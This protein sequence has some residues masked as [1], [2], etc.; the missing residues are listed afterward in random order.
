MIAERYRVGRL[1]GRG[2]M[3]MV[4]VGEHV[5]VG[6]RVA[7]KVMTDNWSRNESI[8]RRFEAEARAASAAGHPNV[9]QVLDV[10]ELDDGRLYSVMEFIEGRDLYTLLWAEHPLSLIRACRLVRDAAFGVRAAHAQG[11]IHR[12]L[13]LE[14]V[15]VQDLREGELVKVLDFGIA[16]GVI[17]GK[18]ATMAGMTMGTPE[19]M[20]PEQV[21]GVDPTVRFDI[22]ALGVMLFE[23]LAKRLPLEDDNPLRLLA[24]KG[25]EPA[26][27]VQTLRQDVPD[28]LDQ[29]V[30]DCL[31]IDP[32]R[33]PQSCEVFIERLSAIVEYL[34]AMVVTPTDPIAPSLPPPRA[35][36]MTRSY[37]D[38]GGAGPSA[39][40]VRVAGQVHSTVVD[41]EQTNPAATVPAVLVGSQPARGAGPL[42]WVLVG[43]FGFAAIA[44]GGAL[45]W[46]ESTA[47]PGPVASAEPDVRVVSSDSLGD[48]GEPELLAQPDPD[49]LDKLDEL[50]EL[51]DSEDLER[52]GASADAR[53]NIGAD[54]VNG[55]DGFA[56]RD[57][58]TE[59][60]L[61]D[62]ALDT[63]PGT[64]A[65]K[66]SA[67]QACAKVRQEASDARQ[68][69]AWQSVLDAT[70]ERK[71]WA[72]ARDRKK[73]QTQAYMEL[74]RFE[75]CL[76][77]GEGLADTEV[78][79]WVKLCSN[80]IE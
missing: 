19:Y 62:V 70:A 51:D 45:I 53:P 41:P 20:A 36:R 7:I 3:G 55:P 16:A 4:Y 37:G 80:R 14:N 24:R 46:R 5:R 47:D 17:T 18:R 58:P 23:L 63:R 22:Y 69:H 33:R 60:T 67:T 21:D 35:S 11:V 43:V 1:V 68:S 26:P 44:T 71:C 73:L 13:K 49:E 72:R 34:D 65:P 75:D 66:P 54:E 56:V 9:I 52:S 10:G 76:R 8:R 42:A 74:G 12:D 79:K 15:M 64:A 50:D 30:A 77:T 2:A 27:R 25:N 48:V 28:S 39:G 40:A 38:R 6:R 59:V 31:E 78:Q 61:A 57:E 32:D 29:L